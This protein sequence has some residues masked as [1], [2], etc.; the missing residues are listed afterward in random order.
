MEWKIHT[1]EPQKR[2]KWMH[3]PSPPLMPTLSHQGYVN[4]DG[5][6]KTS[7]LHPNSTPCFLSHPHATLRCFPEEEEKRALGKAAILFLATG[8]GFQNWGSCPFL[9]EFATWAKGKGMSCVH[10]Q[11]LACRFSGELKEASLGHSEMESAPKELSVVLF[12]SLWQTF[13][14]QVHE[15]YDIIFWLCKPVNDNL[16]NRKQTPPSPVQTTR[17]THSPLAS[18]SQISKKTIRSYL[19]WQG[20]TLGLVMALSFVAG[21]VMERNGNWKPETRGPSH[22]RLEPGFNAPHRKY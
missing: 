16:L 9:L 3:K 20:P 22:L 21:T 14:K 10:K 2:S 19:H 13:P 5:L 1:T 15:S 18:S 8:K 17:A 12:F 11:Y 7:A 6:S 4:I